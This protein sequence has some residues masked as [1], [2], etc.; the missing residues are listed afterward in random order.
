M[1]SF[2]L[3]LGLVLLG[4]PVAIGQVAETLHLPG[5]LPADVTTV[6]DYYKQDVYDT[7]DQKLGQIVDLL[8]HKDGWIPV[9]MIS[10]GSLLKLKSKYVAAPFDALQRL[11]RKDKPYLVL[12][13]SR[14]TLQAAAG[15]TYNRATRRWESV[16]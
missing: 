8:V 5:T 12:D 16:D 11:E 4:R 3:A 15:F 6:A 2:V 10:V 1:K 9:A 14:Q 13:V 7:A